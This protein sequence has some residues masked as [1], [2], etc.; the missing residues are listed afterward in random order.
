MTYKEDNFLVKEN[1]LLRE[2]VVLHMTEIDKL[3]ASNK[4]LKQRVSELTDMINTLNTKY[5]E[6]IDDDCGICD[7][8]DDDISIDVV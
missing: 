8:I 7:D 4:S 2:M 6:T 1:K 5:T 3:K